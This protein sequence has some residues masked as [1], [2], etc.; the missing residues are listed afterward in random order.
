MREMSREDLV[1]FRELRDELPMVM[2]NHAA[3]PRTPGGDRPASTSKYWIA[4][5]LRNRV[6]YRGLI[7]SDDLEMGGILKYMPM[8][9]AVVT[10]VRAGM[11]LMEICHSPEL[12]L[13]AYEALIGEAER[14][15]AF[16][17]TLLA[18]ARECAA[19]RKRL[20][21][22]KQ[23]RALSAGQLRALRERIVAFGERVALAQEA[24]PA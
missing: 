2:V 24:R 4:T 6:G 20:F 8:E 19:K 16:K 1:P 12:I 13:R 18:R 22:G 9:E 5:V 23:A 21:A 17:G 10:A 11:D 3:Y 7:F 15:V 14:S